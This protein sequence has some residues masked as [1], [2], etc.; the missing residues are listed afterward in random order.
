MKRDLSFERAMHF[1]SDLIR[2]P[3][4]PGEEGE[5]ARRIVGELR[6]LGFDEA[7]TDAAGNVIGRVAGTDGAPA[8]MLSSHMDVVDVGDPDG[9]EHDPWGG[10]IT[11]GCLHGRGAMDVKGQ[12]AIQLYA[13][14]RCV[15]ERPAGDV[16]MIC[17]VYEE[18]GGWG[19]MHHMETLSVR[20]GAVILAEATGGE[21]CTGHRGHAELSVDVHGVAAHASAPERGCN[22]NHALPH[23]LL[24]LRSLSDAQPRHPVLGR[25]TLTPTVVETW[26]KSGNVIPDRIRVTL[27]MRVLPGWDEDEA[28]EEIRALLRARV[29]AMDGVSVEVLPGRATHR[30]WTG[31]IDEHS[32]FTPGF[33]LPDEHRVV[34]AAA[35][36]LRGALGRTPAVRQWKFGTDGGHSCGTHG[37]PTI[38]FAP[39]NEALA[40]TNRE[41]LELDAARVAFDA[42]PAL[43]RGVQSALADARGIPVQGIHDAFDAGVCEETGVAVSRGDFAG[44]AA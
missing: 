18:K 35:A 1:A 36:A 19:M 16:R 7:R 14:A 24:A 38:G 5:V 31:W 12:L 15:E 21:L 28:V 42:Y 8:V 30:A 23:V 33:L 20:P 6:A 10:A 26:P 29:P 44:A 43:I 11:G 17:S 13:A 22:P 25:A 34:E 9:W 32:N 41:R 39:G 27:D 2:I 37:I 4:L 3:S 40:H